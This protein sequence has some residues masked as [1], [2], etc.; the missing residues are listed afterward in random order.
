MNTRLS[1]LLLPALL[2][3]PLLAQEPAPAPTP[4]PAPQADFAAHTKQLNELNELDKKQNLVLEGLS[5]QINSQRTLLQDSSGAIQEQTVLYQQCQQR[6]ESISKDLKDALLSNA[7]IKE[8]MSN[9]DKSL[10]LSD[11]ESARKSEK[12]DAFI[13]EFGRQTQKLESEVKLVAELQ[14]QLTTLKSTT[15]ALQEDTQAQLTQLKSTLAGAEM[16]VAMLLADLQET[17]KSV[18]TEAALREEQTSRLALELAQSKLEMADYKKIQEMEQ[19]KLIASMAAG[20]ILLFLCLVTLVFIIFTNSKRLKSA[21][22]AGVA[23]KLQEA[24]TEIRAMTKQPNKPSAK[25][26][27]K[28]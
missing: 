20:M 25:P 14:T 26:R 12:L 24:S 5:E 21:V 2:S 1:S 22:L 3:L 19:D 8:A 23:A 13:L 6:L 16:N 18:A 4:A 28:R 11:G 10:S 15:T 17:K 27:N 9:F 7:Q